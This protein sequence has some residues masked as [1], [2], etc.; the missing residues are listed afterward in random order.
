MNWDSKF[1][2]IVKETEESIARVK[3]S[4]FESILAIFP[5]D[6]MFFLSQSQLQTPLR[7]KV[8]ST[9]FSTHLNS[10]ILKPDRDKEHSSYRRRSVSFD[11]E[12]SLQ[13]QT[14]P[15]KSSGVVMSL[16]TARI[17]DQQKVRDVPQFEK[18]VV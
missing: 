12:P 2:S 14:S 6:C 13:G 10:R 7:S 9:D 17:S 16:L 3:V 11:L 8:P 15:R 4:N 18:N 1:A 5:N